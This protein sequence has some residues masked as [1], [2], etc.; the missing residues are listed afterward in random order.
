MKPWHQTFPRKYW[1]AEDWASWEAAGKPAIPRAMRDDPRQRKPL[2]PRTVVQPDHL[3]P[4]GFQL[5]AKPSRARDARGKQVDHLLQKL[6]IR[7]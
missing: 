7:S 5:Y 1:M 6:G 2:E 3:L 4:S